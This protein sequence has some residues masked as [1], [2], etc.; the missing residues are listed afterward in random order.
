MTHSN[1]VAYFYFLYEAK[2]TWKNW[3]NTKAWLWKQAKR[4]S[5]TMRTNNPSSFVVQTM[6]VQPAL[7]MRVNEIWWTKLFAYDSHVC[8]NVEDIGASLIYPIW[9]RDWPPFLSLLIVLSSYYFSHDLKCKCTQHKICWQPSLLLTQ[10][11]LINTGFLGSF[12]ALDP[13]HPSLLPQMFTEHLPGE[14]PGFW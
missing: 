14:A 1:R 13:P 2:N 3:R 7:H 9:R 6:T 8:G 4:L 12:L 10:S 11:H 5:G